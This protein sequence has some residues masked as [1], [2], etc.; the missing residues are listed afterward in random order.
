MDLGVLLTVR[1]ALG[2]L[3][4]GTWTGPHPLA[5]SGWP[6]TAAELGGVYAGL[7]L[8]AGSD[9]R[10][11]WLGK[12]YRGRGLATR[13]R[14]HLDVPERAAEFHHLYVVEALA[15]SPPAAI[16][17][18]EGKAAD[19]L[20]LRATMSGRRWPSSARWP[21]LV[22]GFRDPLSPSMR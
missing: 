22:A 11:R 2:P 15:Y 8:A 16:E 4:A 1:A 18:A 19:L 20:R 17:C 21:E 12:A 3:A 13:I 5:A 9:G 14:E 6:A 7:Y 10:L